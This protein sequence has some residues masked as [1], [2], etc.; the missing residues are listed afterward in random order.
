MFTASMR[1]IGL[2]FLQAAVLTLLF[3]AGKA[4]GDAADQLA[5]KPV[6]SLSTHL[7][8]PKEDPGPEKVPEGDAPASKKKEKKGDTGAAPPGAPGPKTKSGS[9]LAV[10]TIAIAIGLSGVSAALYFTLKSLKRR[11]RELRYIQS[12]GNTYLREG[13]GKDIYREML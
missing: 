12:S 10:I 11:N 6:F 4:S 9:L 3:A 1:V 5:P 2:I 8:E 7:K 13:D